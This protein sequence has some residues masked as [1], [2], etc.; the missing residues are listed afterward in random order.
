MVK[1]VRLALGVATALALIFALSLLVLL[2]LDWNRAKPWLNGHISEALGRPFNIKGNLSLSWEKPTAPAPGWKSWLPWPH[3]LAQDIHI[4]NPRAWTAATTGPAWPEEMASLRQLSFSLDPWAL[5]G[6][7]IVIPT[8]QFDGPAITLIH[9]ADGKNNW[10]FAHAAAPLAW[11]IAVHELVFAAGNVHLIDAVRRADVTA[12]IHTQHTDAIYGM[13]WQLQGTVNGEPITGSGR[14]GAVLAWQQQGK[15]YPLEADLRMGKTHINV[16][17][18]YAH[19]R[20]LPTFDLQLQLAAVSMDKLYALSGI[21]LP[22]T[23]PFSTEGRLLGTL[24]EKG[25]HWF[26]EHFVGKV[27]SS[28][29]SGNLDYQARQPRPLLSGVVQSH[30]LQF[31]D[32]A[33]VVGA[34]TRASKVARG[35]T[36]TQPQGKLLPHEPFKFERWQSIDADVKY[37]AEQVLRDRKLPINKLTATIHLKDGVLSLLPLDFGMAGGSLRADVVLNGTGGAGVQATTQVTAQHLQ[38]NQLLPTLQA[39]HA[40]AGEMNGSAALSAKGVSV[41]SLLGNANGEIKASIRNGTLS[42][43]MLEEMGINIVNIVLT[44]LSGDTQV[45]LNCMSSDFLVQQGMMQ[46]RSVIVDTA[47]ATIRVSG[48]INLATEEMDL[49]I[50]PDSKGLR[51]LSL[52]TPL[53]VTG[54]FMQ[55]Q[56]RVDKEVLALKI[57]G[58]AALAALTP[59][60]ALIPLTKTGQQTTEDCGKSPVQVNAKPPASAKLPALK[61]H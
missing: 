28:D 52:R 31:A 39:M 14:A 49:N 51:L 57:G 58:A 13:D 8:L 19:T 23:P 61:A 37:S 48:T 2:N 18:S 44:R 41:A 11:K 50:R 7:K 42:S 1:P 43:L 4:G 35:A 34:D 54:S 15:A 16:V 36:S 53:H 24:S 21:T 3:L 12:T 56:V 29:I 10:A 26:Y 30:L 25:N 59:F 55:P 17:G 6:R 60:A 45:T 33:P 5:L 32:L 38:L 20:G 27:G 40:S 9:T 22:Q 47:T 46:A